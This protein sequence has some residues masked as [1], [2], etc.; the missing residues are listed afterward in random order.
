MFLREN[1]IQIFILSRFSFINVLLLIIIAHK[2]ND[3]GSISSQL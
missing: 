2:L 1:R 3:E